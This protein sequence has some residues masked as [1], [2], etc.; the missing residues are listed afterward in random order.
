[1][2]ILTGVV[3]VDTAALAAHLK[4]TPAY[5]RLMVSRGVITP[6]DRRV[7][8]GRGRPT[9]FFNALQV[10]EELLEAER[11]GLARL[12]NGRWRVRN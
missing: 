6:S 12:D 2:S 5:V 4:C 8:Q 10:D 9:M 3:E 1:M 7:R 11:Q